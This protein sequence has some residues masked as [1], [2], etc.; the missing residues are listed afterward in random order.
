[1]QDPRDLLTLSQVAAKL[2]CSVRH[3]KTLIEQGEILC[4]QLKPDAPVKKLERVERK[5][6]WRF[7]DELEARA[8]E[9]G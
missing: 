1:M 3:L 4:L 2:Q 7:L 6:L 9:G 5:E 8:L